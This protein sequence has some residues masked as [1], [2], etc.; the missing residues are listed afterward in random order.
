LQDLKTALDLKDEAFLASGSENR[1]GVWLSLAR[2]Y[3]KAG[4][5]PNMLKAQ[6]E[7][8]VAAEKDTSVPPAIRTSVLSS[9][10]RSRGRYYWE[11]GDYER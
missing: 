9:A 5:N 7:A 4:D 2:V 1:T 8:I 3:R 10:L 6:N 11:N